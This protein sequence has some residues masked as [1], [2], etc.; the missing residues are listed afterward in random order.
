MDTSLIL[1]IYLEAIGHQVYKSRINSSVSTNKP[2]KSGKWANTVKSIVDH[3]YLP[4][5]PAFTF[6][7]DESIVECRRCT[8][9][10]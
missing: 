8:I 6:I 3:P 9:L 10:Y 2:F 1:D 5:Q 4:N 7:E